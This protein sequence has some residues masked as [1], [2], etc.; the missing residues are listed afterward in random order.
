MASAITKPARFTPTALLLG[1]LFLAALLPRFIQLDSFVTP[2][3]RRWL[4]RS[5]NFYYALNRDD[6][7]TT[8]Q[9]GHPGVTVMWAGTAGFLTTF[10]SYATMATR[11]V[12]EADFDAWMQAKSNVSSL[13]LLVAGRRWIVLA[14]SLLIAATY[15]PLSNL[16]GSSP[17]F[18]AMLFVA[19]EPFHIGLSRQL[20]PDGLL[21]T[22]VLFALT[23]FAAWIYDRL[24]GVYL[25]LAGI[26]TGLAVLTKSPALIVLFVM[27]LVILSEWGVARHKS[28]RRAMLWRGG[29]QLLLMSAITF[30]VL[31][32]A[33]WLG[34][35]D[36]FMRMFNLALEYS[37][38]GHELPLYFLGKTVDDPGP[39]FYQVSLLMRA[40]PATLIGLL[41]A[42]LGLWYG[43]FP[44]RAWKVIHTLMAFLLFAALFIAIISVSEK[45]MDRYL[46]PAMP[47]LTVVAAVGWTSLVT[48]IGPFLRRRLPV[49]WRRSLA[50]RADSGSTLKI[51]RLIN[52]GLLV[53]PLIF[54]HGIFSAFNFPY[55]LTYYNPLF[56]GSRSAPNIMMIG[57]G[58]GLEAAAKWL[59]QQSLAA[60][61]V[62]A[63]YGDGPLSY[64]LDPTIEILPFFAGG[65]ATEEFW[66][67][68]DYAVLYV[69]QW[70]RRNP[71]AEVIDYFLSGTP[72]YTVTFAGLDLVRIYALRDLP[73]P[74]ST[75]LHRIDS[76]IWDEKIEL[77]GYF[78][79]DETVFPGEKISL[80]LFW[81]AINTIDEDYAL[82]LNLLDS[83]GQS[84]WS[85]TRSPAGI[86]TNDWPIRKIWHDAYTLE[87]PPD[88]APGDYRLRAIFQRTSGERLP[89]TTLALDAA[90]GGTS[91][92]M[93][94]AT[95]KVPQSVMI[96]VSNAIWQGAKV[97]TVVHTEAATLGSSFFVDVNAAVESDVPLKLSLRLLESSGATLAQNDQLFE[98]TMRFRLLIPATAS[99]G[100]YTLAAVLYDP[101]TLAALPDQQGTFRVDI[102]SVE[103]R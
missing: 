101:A 6:Y 60:G 70:Q 1:M 71:S 40:T 13:D 28:E 56:G 39:L 99:P 7:L 31:W 26:A 53:I 64:Y 102:L 65:D 68:A 80:A 17:A 36:A 38:Q 93:I 50:L 103:V 55:Y 51:N 52:V 19:W 74:E 58:E 94:V 61:R 73:P 10:P 20:H 78:L 35:Q 32:P 96:E 37:E 97:K 59:N 54:L 42:L 22:L 62:V 25:L 88:L 98:A 27:L 18:V 83:S 92:E 3:E 90:E 21:A 76:T 57:W 95:L 5:A 33:A 77:L 15:L 49:S 45:K 4:Q 69:N 72:A 48:V 12:N 9:A 41:L 24:R 84:V 87:I 67:D 11:P 16:L 100:S 81:R 29:I 46:L 91:D 89:L 82:Q 30:V 43:W 75:H 23:T 14:I 34:P 44:L 85:A 8:Y 79:K 86:D 2:D 66:F 63:W 47:V